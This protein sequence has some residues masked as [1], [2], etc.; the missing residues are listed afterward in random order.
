LAQGHTLRVREFDPPGLLPNE[1]VVIFH[2]FSSEREMM[3]EDTFERAVS[4]AAGTVA[5]L[6]N[7][8]IRATFVADFMNWNPLLTH[9][10]S[11]YYEYLS[12]LADSQ[13]AI[14]TELHELQSAID[15]VLDIQ[16]LIIVS[17]MPADV[18]QDLV[19]LPDG[20][21]V[22]DIRQVHFPFKKTVS[23][24]EALSKSA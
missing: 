14:G 15:G 8:N 19:A 24:K 22:V 10:R 11:Q 4:L 7:L 1:A 5:Y 20:A 3:R 21:T 13:R 18:W 16:Q 2:S 12:I 6:R 17:D 23:A 9:T